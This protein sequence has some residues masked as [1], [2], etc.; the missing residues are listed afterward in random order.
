M[1]TMSQPP[2]P[3]QSARPEAKVVTLPRATIKSLRAHIVLLALW[4]LLLALSF[5]PVNWW[6]LAHVS[7]VPLTLVAIRSAHPRRM[8]LGVWLAGSVWWLTMGWWVTLTTMAG[9]IVLGFYLALY[10]WGF[11]WTIRAVD[12]RFRWPLVFTVPIVW[13]GLEYLRGSWV[14]TGYPWFLLGQSQPTAL[15]Q[16]ADLVGAYGVSFV[17]AMT[18]GALCDLVTR[19][20]VS[21]AKQKVFGFVPFKYNAAILYCGCAIVMTVFYGAIMEKGVRGDTSTIRVAVV[22]TNVPQ[23]NKESPKPEADAEN[24]AEMV[25]LT[26]KAVAG[27]PKPALVVWPETMVPRPLDAESVDIFRRSGRGEEAYHDQLL[28]LATETGVPMIVGAHRYTWTGDGKATAWNLKRR[29]N[30]AYLIEPGKPIEQ[31]FDKIHRVPFGEFIPGAEA[32]PAFKDWLISLTPYNYDYTLGKGRSYTRFAVENDDGQVWRVAAPICFEDVVSYVP[33]NMV[34]TVGHDSSPVALTKH[35]DLLVNLSND[36]WF[37]GSSELVQH[38]QIAR[39]RCV[40]NRVPMARA[41]NRGA[42]GFIDSSGRLIGGLDG[43]PLDQAGYDVHD[44]VR[45]PRTTVFAYIGDTFAAVC[46]LVT[47]GLITANL[48]ARIRQRKAKP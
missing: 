9:G 27:D 33:R 37:L 16:I 48:V 46:F 42:S 4:V 35:V 13:V 11:A 45:D 36:G 21:R 12:R 40:E 25:R 32:I 6:P 30:S 47:L 31:R 2:Q 44:L 20:M 1:P 24:F 41:V 15:I 7:L 14:L 39:F 17:V 3:P 19:P 29:Y 22:Q 5:P 34:Y 43:M 10:Y 26:R 38:R 28:R 23:D 8:L 18:S